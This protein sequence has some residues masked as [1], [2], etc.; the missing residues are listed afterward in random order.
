MKQGGQFLAF[1]GIMTAMQQF[2]H[3]EV[4]PQVS[5]DIVT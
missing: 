3:V 2:L 4:A 5:T 1:N